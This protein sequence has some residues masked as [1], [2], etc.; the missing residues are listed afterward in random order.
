MLYKNVKV[1]KLALSFFSV[2]DIKLICALYRHRQT[3]AF[4][5]VQTYL[6]LLLCLVLL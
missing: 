1:Y 5:K 3:C 2:I 4:T 6:H